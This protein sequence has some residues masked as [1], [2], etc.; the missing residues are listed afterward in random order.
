MSLAIVMPLA[1]PKRSTPLSMTQVPVVLAASI[2]QLRPP[3]VGSVSAT[4]TPYAEPGPLDV[5]VSVKPIGSPADTDASSA[6]LVSLISAG[7]TWK[8]SVVLLVW[9]SARYLEPA[10]G[11]YAT[12]KQ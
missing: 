6:T 11:V 10:S 8:H 9:L 7:M 4:L 1:P 5:I 2:D 3:S 12:R